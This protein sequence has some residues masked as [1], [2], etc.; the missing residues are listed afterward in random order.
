M[1]GAWWEASD[2]M[3]QR[4]VGNTAERCPWPPQAF[5]V[6]GQLPLMAVPPARLLRTTAQG[7]K[8]DFLNHL[9][10]PG[11]SLPASPNLLA[12]AGPQA[13]PIPAIVAGP[14][15]LELLTKGEDPPTGLM[16][17]T[18]VCNPCSSNAGL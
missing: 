9:L 8:C 14:W 15:G 17:E 13:R 7:E 16:S 2:C 11:C 10:L 18:R 1:S 4:Q 3:W 5:G 12:L 6:A